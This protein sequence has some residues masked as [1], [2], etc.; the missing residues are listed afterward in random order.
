MSKLELFTKQIGLINGVESYILVRRS[1]EIIADNTSNSED[2]ASMVTM[3]G[4]GA[5]DI[6][7]TI[8]FT[9][10]KHLSFN[11]MGKRNFL[12]FF[13]NRYFLGIQQIAGTDDQQLATEISQLLENLSQ[14]DHNEVENKWSL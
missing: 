8:G 2:L 7:Q 10:F 13:L 1:G 11:R 12:L 5:S 4:L 14:Q 6:M 9:Q 3:C